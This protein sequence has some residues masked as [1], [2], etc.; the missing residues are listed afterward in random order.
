MIRFDHIDKS[1]FTHIFFS[2]FKNLDTS[3]GLPAQPGFKHEPVYG[4]LK[5]LVQF[6]NSNPLVLYG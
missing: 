6:D 5:P 2:L 1:K 4:Q 3:V